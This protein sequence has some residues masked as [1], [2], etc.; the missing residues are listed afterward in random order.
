MPTGGMLATSSFTASKIAQV[1]HGG[2]G[3]SPFSGYFVALFAKLVAFGS[4]SPW[5]SGCDRMATNTRA[6]AMDRSAPGS[7]RSLLAR[8][9]CR[10]PVP[11]ECAPNGLSPEDVRKG[12]VP[13]RLKKSQSSSS[14]R[15]GS[16]SSHER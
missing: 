13:P 2:V 6:V 1:L 5:N 14:H 10:P 7:A 3:A 16:V 15:F 8:E 9:P 4:A 12:R 11:P